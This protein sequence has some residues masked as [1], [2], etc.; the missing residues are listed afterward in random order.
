M[1][2]QSNPIGTALLSVPIAG[3]MLGA[4]GGFSAGAEAWFLRITRIEKL[5][6]YADETFKSPSF[7]KAFTYIGASFAVGGMQTQLIKVI[8]QN[9]VRY[10]EKYKKAYE[11][12]IIFLQ[13][14]TV[15]GCA[16]YLRS[17]GYHNIHDMFLSFTILAGHVRAMAKVFSPPEM[18]EV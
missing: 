9:T 2:G 15:Y 11:I 4:I 8:D 3:V 18:D 10:Q 13:C 12:T 7:K 14:M 5:F 6:Q 17:Q 16:R 1:S